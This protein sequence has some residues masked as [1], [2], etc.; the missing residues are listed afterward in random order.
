MGNSADKAI[1]TIGHILST[2]C[3]CYELPHVLAAL[4]KAALILTSKFNFC[5]VTKM[6]QQS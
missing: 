2:I 1:I 5:S 3:D 6:W 4:T